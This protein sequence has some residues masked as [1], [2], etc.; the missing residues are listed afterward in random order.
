MHVYTKKGCCDSVQP[1]VRKHAK[2]GRGLHSC[3]CMPRGGMTHTHV[4]AYGLYEEGFSVGLM[5]NLCP[6]GKLSLS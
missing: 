5:V 1:Q 2:I 3:L 6:N 4:S